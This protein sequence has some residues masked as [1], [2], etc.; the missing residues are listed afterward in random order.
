MSPL[1]ETVAIMVGIDKPQKEQGAPYLG[2][3]SHDQEV[4]PAPTQ[5]SSAMTA[6]ITVLI[7]TPTSALL[8]T[9][10]RFFAE[11]T[12]DAAK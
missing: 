6:C 5:L 1:F 9:Q 7:P 2:V 4:G 8:S 11:A 3:D 10:L 12:A